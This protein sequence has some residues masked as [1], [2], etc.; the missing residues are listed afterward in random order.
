MNKLNFL[1]FIILITFGCKTDVKI[2]FEKKDLLELKQLAAEGD[3]AKEEIQKLE[4]WYDDQKLSS[5]TDTRDG[6]EYKTILMRDGKIWFAEN[7]QFKTP[8]SWCYDNRN[9]LCKKYGRL[10]Y[11]R[12]A[13]SA[14][15]KGWHLPTDKEWWGLARQYGGS[16]ESFL[17]TSLGSDEPN[18][19]A[20]YG[21]ISYSFLINN[22]KTKFN[23]TLSGF[24]RKRVLFSG[25]SFI[26]RNRRGHYWSAD[27]SDDEGILY[28]SF[29]SNGSSSN[30][31]RISIADNK[32]ALSCRCVKD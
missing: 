14:C 21:N 12:N 27:N 9:S 2:A 30:M 6:K 26:N 8:N 11:W 28:Y 4:K 7:L 16:N 13:L 15:P 19:D 24:R 5:F 22:G 1:L 18:L 25:F 32:N 10:Y 3:D 20:T 17:I 23:A 29:L 31:S